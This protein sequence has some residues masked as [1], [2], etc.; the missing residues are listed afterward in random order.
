[1]RRI[2]FQN[3]TFC[4]AQNRQA[5][6]HPFTS[7]YLPYYYTDLFNRSIFIPHKE[8]EV[9]IPLQGQF[10]GTF[11][12][13]FKIL[14]DDSTLAAWPLGQAQSA[15]LKQ[16]ELT[17]VASLSSLSNKPFRLARLKEE[18]LGARRRRLHNVTSCLR[19]SG[20]AA[21]S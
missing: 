5:F 16:K 10:R 4:D 19:P 14:P 12:K 2:C 3:P 1:M 21:L 17:M 15:N 18:A 6:L 13:F 20:L 9:K 11:S 7:L 8:P